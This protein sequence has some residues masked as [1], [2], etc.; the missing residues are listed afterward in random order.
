M[1]KLKVEFPINEGKEGFTVLLS[2]YI[3]RG[4]YSMAKYIVNT[5]SEKEVHRTTYQK[6]ACNINLIKPENRLDTD[7]DY[8]VTQ[9]KV[10][11]GCKHC[12]DEKHRK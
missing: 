4:W 6:L 2:K 7:T 11:D 3:V 8:T 5:G 9:P 10:Y 1:S 12:Y